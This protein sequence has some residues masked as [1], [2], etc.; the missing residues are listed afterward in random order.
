MAT[1]RRGPARVMNRLPLVAFLTATRIARRAPAER[2]EA[3]TEARGAR[4]SGVRV[5]GVLSNWKQ[6]LALCQNRPILS[7]T[8]CVIAKVEATAG[9]CRVEASAGT[10]CQLMLPTTGAVRFSIRFWWRWG[11]VELP[12]QDVQPEISYER[13]RCFVVDRSSRH[14]QRPVRSIH[15]PL[16]ALRPVTWPRRSRIPAEL[17]FHSPRG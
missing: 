7:V 1:L 3:S 11:R 15:V 6:Q 10:N 16:R 9:R 8:I 2:S 13:S 4:S 12:V 14:R 5:Y 17:R